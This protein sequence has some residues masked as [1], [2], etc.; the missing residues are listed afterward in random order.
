MQLLNVFV[1]SSKL[2]NK[3]ALFSLNRVGMRDTLVYLFLVFIVAFLP[4]V[5]LSI[6]SFPTR[7]ATIP[8]SLYIL[9]LIVFYPLL[10]MFLV[11]SGV[12][13]LTCGSWVIKVINKR[14]LAFAQLWKM[15]GYALTLPLFFY[16]L[17]Y[18]LGIP[19]RW[20]TIIFAIILYGI[21]FLTIRVYPKPATKK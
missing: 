15:T 14:K 5:I 17:L 8:F 11:V 13:F 6:I 20:A 10:M 7:E 4:N 1:N 16:N 12:T 9:Q 3:Q 21:M 19:I 18:L 2:P